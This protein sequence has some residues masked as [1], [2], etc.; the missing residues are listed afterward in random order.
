M[1]GGLP[2]ATARGIF[3][4]YQRLHPSLRHRA[5]WRIGLDHWR[6]IRVDR[7]FMNLV[8]DPF[9]LTQP[10]RFFDLPVKFVSE[11]GVVLAI[12]VGDEDPS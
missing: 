11:E 6:A 10:T 1:N 9:D 4:V 5:Y 2:D 7:R 3:E 12:Y 8:V